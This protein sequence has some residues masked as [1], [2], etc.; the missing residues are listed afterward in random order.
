MA[1]RRVDD[2]HCVTFGKVAFD[3]TFRPVEGKRCI[4]AICRVALLSVRLS[5]FIRVPLACLDLRSAPVS[6]SSEPM[7]QAAMLNWHAGRAAFTL[8]SDAAA[9]CSVVI[10]VFDDYH[11]LLEREVVA[12]QGVVTCVTAHAV[13]MLN[14]VPSAG[15]APSVC[16]L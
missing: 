13:T 6:G 2:E 11:L 14:P 7:L 16:A 12:L 1:S 8:C 15:A 10:T 4:C 5:L 3:Y 9:R